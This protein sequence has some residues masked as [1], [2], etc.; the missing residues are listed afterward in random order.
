MCDDLC[1]LSV[2]PG[3]A[4]GPATGGRGQAVP[5]VGPH[6]LAG[7]GDRGGHQVLHGGATA[8]HQE[9]P[10]T[11]SAGR[12]TVEGAGWRGGPAGRD[13]TGRGRPECQVVS[14]CSRPVSAR[15]CVLLSRDAACVVCRRRRRR[16]R[17]ATDV[18]AGQR[19]PPD[20]PSPAGRPAAPPA[21]PPAR[22]PA[23]SDPLLTLFALSLSLISGS[24]AVSSASVSS[25]LRLAR[26]H[27][28]LIART[29]SRRTP[30]AAPHV[31]HGARVRL[32]QERHVA[33]PSAGVR[34]CGRSASRPALA[35]E[36]PTGSAAAA[37]CGSDHRHGIPAVSAR[38]RTAAS[39]GRAASLSVCYRLSLSETSCGEHSSC[40]SM[41]CRS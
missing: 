13:G 21:T 25:C 40:L 23:R 29:R 8:L 18:C 7:D 31:W 28:A 32:L 15:R 30:R 4:E 6:H 20:T 10:H 11:V 24:L 36:M 26:V 1:P 16:R 37:G 22:P 33:A 9:S 12:W 39:A 27:G 2:R 41:C 14:R 34:V 17:V 3:G 19:A 38:G 5:R 35:P